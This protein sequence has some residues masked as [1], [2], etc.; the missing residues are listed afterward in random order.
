MVVGSVIS[1]FCQLQ[2]YDTQAVTVD[3]FI[4]RIG[5]CLIN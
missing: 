4:V 3:A 1:Y 2:F 5:P